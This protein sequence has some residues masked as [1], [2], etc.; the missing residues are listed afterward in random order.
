MDLSLAN[1]FYKIAKH[2]VEK[3]NLS[4]NNCLILFNSIICPDVQSNNQK[5]YKT[6]K[7]DDLTFIMSIQLLN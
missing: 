5:N 4:L 7:Y 6:F 1:E 2:V 3:N